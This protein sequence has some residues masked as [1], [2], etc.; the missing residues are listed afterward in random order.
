MIYQQN[1]KSTQVCRRKGNI[2]DCRR[3][4]SVL[5]QKSC[6]N[7]IM[8]SLQYCKLKRKSQESGKEWM[9]KLQT[10]AADYDYNKHN[11]KLTEQFIHGLDDEGIISEI[12]REIAAVENVG[13]ATSEQILL[14]AQR[15][16]A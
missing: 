4:F 13:D 5:S 3:L 2:Q 1:E 8:L 16:E 6:H 9:G 12:L 15:L 10:K 14:W 11:S 7:R